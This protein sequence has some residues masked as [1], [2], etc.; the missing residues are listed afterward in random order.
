MN[1]TVHDAVARCLGRAFAGRALRGDRLARADGGLM[2]QGEQGGDEDEGVVTQA[3]SP[4]RDA[5]PKPRIA[6]FSLMSSE[7]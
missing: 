3:T 1:F 5:M 4:M 2:E 7:P 6:R